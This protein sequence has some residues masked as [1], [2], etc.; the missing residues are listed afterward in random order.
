M[1]VQYITKEQLIAFGWRGITDAMLDDLN[2]TLERYDIT[3]P[4]RIAHFISQCGHESGLG[5]YT[6]ELASGSAYEGRKDLG[7]KYPGDG[8]RYKGAGYIQLTGRNN[9]QA[10]AN[11]VGD[12]SVMQGVDYVA[13]KYPWS[14]AG[15][16]WARAAMNALIDSGATVEQV[17]RRVNGGYNGLAD[18]KALHARWTEQNP[19][20]ELLKVDK[21]AYEFIEDVM[22]DYWKRM[23]GN[24]EVQKATN[25]AMNALRRATGNEEE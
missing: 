15:F 21:W 19:E 22:K 8:P 10:F 1:S 16:W 3:T 5:K 17:S 20:K 18:R 9:Y 11:G 7:N 6:K 12:Q 13:V 4:T 2:Y 24:E 23:N 25:A 14:S